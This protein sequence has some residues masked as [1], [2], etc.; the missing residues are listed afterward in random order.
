MNSLRTTRRVVRK[1]TGM[2]FNMWHIKAISLLAAIGIVLL[3]NITTLQERIITVPLEVVMPQN[4]VP[5]AELARSVQ[6]NLRGEGDE[7]VAII[8]EDI[9]AFV[10]LRQYQ[11]VGTVNAS[12]QLERL[13]GALQVD[14]LEV[15]SV[16]AQVSVRIEERIAK[17][18][19]VELGG[20]AGTRRGYRVAQARLS[21][22]SL[23]VTGPRSVIEN[24]ETLRSVDLDLN[25]YTESFVT[26]LEVL[27]VH[28]YMQF[29]RGDTVSVRVN[30]VEV[31][32]TQTINLPQ[33]QINNLRR[34]LSASYIYEDGQV[35]IEGVLSALNQLPGDE[36]FLEIDAEEINS[37]GV[38]TLAVT[39]ALPE[40]F[41]SLRVV[42][43]TPK[44]LLVEVDN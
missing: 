2:L 33:L 15:S 35:V 40:E 39:A 31:P 42:D 12:V 21:P 30:I 9:R 24:L 10:D 38:Y 13:G 37:P 16:P 29:T 19:R 14:P 44:V 18:V 43:F 32:I 4:Y 25:E 6:V 1:W 17:V 3:N 34:N 41:E 27:G 36:V 26:E 11:T 7:I 22:A 23:E 20:G 28:E 5:S 8:S